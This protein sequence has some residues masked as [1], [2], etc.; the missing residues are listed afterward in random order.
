MLTLREK[1][2]LRDLMLNEVLILWQTDELRDR[3]PTVTDEVRKG[4]YYFDETLFE[5]LPNVYAELERS[6]TKYYPGEAWHIPTFLKF[7][8]WIGGDRD[9]N[10]SVTPEVTWNTLLMHRE[11][12]LKKYEEAL[13]NLKVH[14]SF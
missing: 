9:G 8:S 10:P 1:E 14:M 12:V 5:V 3:K 7:G 4:L 13:N 2:D 6:L 11:L